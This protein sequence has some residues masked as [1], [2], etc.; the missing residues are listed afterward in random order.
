MKKVSTMVFISVSSVLLLAACS[1]SNGDSEEEKEL[2]LELPLKTTSIAPYETDVPVQ[3]GAAES[4]FKMTTDG[5]LENLLVEDY[6]QPS[7]EQLELTLKDDITFQNEEKL[8]GEKVKKSLELSL[9]ERDLLQSP[10]H[11]EDVEED[12]QKVT[13]TT[14]YEHLD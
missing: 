4:L 12:R 3:A 13:I 5:K 1:G 2:H 7:P 11:I 10:L 9:E 14:E 6:E 8:T